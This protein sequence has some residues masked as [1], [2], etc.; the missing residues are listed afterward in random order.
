MPDDNYTPPSI[1]AAFA[2]ETERI[3]RQIELDH[4]DN[5]Q[6][7]EHAAAMRASI[8]GLAPK[9]AVDPRTVEQQ[10]HDRAFG[11]TLT[12]DRPQLPEHLAAVIGRDV[13]GDV[14]DKAV[15]ERHL[16]NAGIEYEPTLEAARAVLLRTGSTVKAES[17]SAHALN[18]L[19]VYGE[20]LRRYSATRPK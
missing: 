12:N 19:A 9:P 1:S 13:A 11:V 15:V 7:L 18:Q 5:A 2:A 20:H 17:L 4:K 10:R 6:W 16:G 14:P 8:A 3:A